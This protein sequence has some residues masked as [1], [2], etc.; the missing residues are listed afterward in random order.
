MGKAPIKI[1]ILDM[2]E[3]VPNLGMR[4]IHNIIKDWSIT[5]DQQTTVKVYNTRGNAEIPDEHYDLYISSGGPGSPLDTVNEPWDIAF[6]EWLEK[7]YTLEKPVFLICHSF[8]LAC[9]HFELGT[10]CLRKS[11]QIGVLPVHTLIEDDLFKELQETFYALESRSYQII[12]PND[13]KIKKMGAQILALEKMRPKIPL[14]RAIMA[15][16]FSETMYG[17]QFHPEADL[18]ELR[19]YFNEASTK[20][21]VIN[22][23]SIEKW[24]RII[25]HLDEHSP[26]I[27]THKYLMP[28]FL[29]KAIT[30]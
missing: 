7:M 30:T 21:T 14:E 26:I 15:I 22:E 1:A 29:D 9:R 27:N 11:K 8:Q 20:E 10:V 12:A 23:F 4:C 19:I 13:E 17:V 18:E 28:N 5:R 6:T 24:N 2:Y 25:D 3:G 16:K